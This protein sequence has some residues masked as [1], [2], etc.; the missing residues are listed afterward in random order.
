MTTFRVRVGSIRPKITGILDDAFWSWFMAQRNITL[1]L[2]SVAPSYHV[3]RWE[4]A[5]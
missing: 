3:R 5:L 1:D 2:R 4:I